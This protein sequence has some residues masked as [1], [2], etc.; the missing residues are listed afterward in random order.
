MIPKKIIFE[1]LSP[2]FIFL[3]ENLFEENI[4]EKIFDSFRIKKPTTIRVNSLKSTRK[5]II[6]ELKN[7][8]LKF[9]DFNLIKDVFIFKENIDKEILNYQFYKDGKIYVQNISSMLPAVILE[10]KP[11]EYI[12]DL[13]AAPGSKTS[14]IAALTNNKA[15]IDAIE[16]DYIRF[17]RLKYNI[18]HLGVKNVSLYN[19]K[20]ENFIKERLENF[21]ITEDLKNENILYDKILFDAPCS[22]EG[23][24]SYFDINSYSNWSLKNVKKLK[25]LQFNILDLSLKLLK[26]G[27]EIVYSTCTLNPYENE[28][29]INKVLEKNKN[30]KIVDIDRKYKD[31]K[32]SIKP[33]NQFYSIDYIDYL[34]NDKEVK[35]KENLKYSREKA[36]NR[37]KSE[38]YKI[39]EEKFEEIRLKNIKIEENIS[40]SYEIN[41]CLRI[42]PDELFEGF[43]I[44]KLKKVK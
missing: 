38:S 16:P 17:Q 21:K 4:R 36:K 24:F 12:L 32:V 13:A 26:E 40:V 6:E 33:L 42:I 37:T 19:I 29:V 31:L 35:E 18:E 2:D 3:I 43:F 7:N 39:Y 27:G 41:K 34:L 30:I 9:Y 1:K 44:C 11:E 28:E 5:E 10:P 8:N 25:K 15:K 22:G 14:Y 23:R 20:A